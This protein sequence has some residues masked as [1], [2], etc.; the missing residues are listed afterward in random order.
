MSKLILFLVA[1]VLFLATAI[2]FHSGS[3]AFAQ[4]ETASPPGLT[5]IEISDN[6]KELGFAVV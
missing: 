1:V 3:Q 6:A 4:T 5:Q 2:G